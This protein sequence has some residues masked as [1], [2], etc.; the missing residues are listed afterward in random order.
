MGWDQT[1][2]FRFHFLSH[3][4]PT[5]CLNS[6]SQPSGHEQWWVC[7]QLLLCDSQVELSIDSNPQQRFLSFCVP[8]IFFFFFFN[9]VSA[10]NVSVHDAYCF[11]FLNLN[12][13]CF[14]QPAACI[15][16]LYFRKLLVSWFILCLCA[17]KSVPLYSIKKTNK[18]KER[19]FNPEF[20]W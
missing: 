1:A 7:W 20:V 18:Q 14:L 4:G 10:T 17:F 3:V 9:S 13:E 15:L 6:A 16:Q 11:S 8:S 12:R 5:H 2:H 19:S